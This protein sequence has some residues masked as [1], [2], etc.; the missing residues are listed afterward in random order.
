MSEQAAPKRLTGWSR[1]AVD[2]GPL[3]VFLVGFF[4]GGKLVKAAGAAAGAQWCLREGAEMYVAILL[5]TP[6][7]AAA[8]LYSW[9]RERRVAPMMLASAVIIAAM[10][11]LTFVLHDKTFFFMKPTL[12]YLLFA[13]LLG[14]GLMTGRNFLKTLFD[15]ALTLPE[16]AWRALT[17][18]YAV[19]FVA[20]AVANEIAWRYLTRDCALASA[21]QAGLGDFLRDCAAAPGARCAG[22]A[23]WVNLK[24]FGFT[25]ANVVFAL[26][27]TPFL[28]KHG[29]ESGD[30]KEPPTSSP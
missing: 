10:G 13:G 20:L 19:F 18:R 30:V 3:L 29:R 5:F 15:G 24:V 25:G 4:Y 16:P 14:G 9:W 27:Q 6:A 26:A 7:F 17:I 2:F 21:P 22:E 12:V 8:F 23:A 1:F 11:A 28:L